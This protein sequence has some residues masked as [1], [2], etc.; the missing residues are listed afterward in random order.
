MWI[1]QRPVQLAPVTVKQK[2]STY[3]VACGKSTLTLNERQYQYF[4]QLLHGQS[5]YS[6][7]QHFIKNGWLINFRELFGLLSALVEQ[8]I[9]INPEFHSFFQMTKGPVRSTGIQNMPRVG[10]RILPNPENLKSMPFFRTLPKELQNQFVANTTSTTLP[11]QTQICGTGDLSRQ[12]Y[13]LVDGTAGIYKNFGGNE[14]QLL[15]TVAPGSP[16]GEGGFFTG[17]PRAADIITLSESQILVIEHTPEFSAMIESGHAEILQKRFWVLNGLLS[18]DLF[19]KLPAETLDSLIFAG[20]IRE[21]KENEVVI[22]EGEQGRSFFIL[23]QG[24]M[25][26]TLK[27]KIVRTCGQGSV[28]GEVALMIS[29]GLRTLTVAA[30]RDSLVVEMDMKEFYNVMSKNLML[31]K[32]IE[33]L[34][35]TRYQSVQGMKE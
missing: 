18:S 29:G 26:M 3:L 2:G 12:M 32:T 14:R 8:N 1:E 20:S 11:P 9:I 31:A 6:L 17:K 24:A 27:D 4:D 25:K 30:Q 21:V 10:K 19:S 22:R 33:E 16:F 5:I 35:W 23:T 7:V 15:S 34:A 13:V 28:F